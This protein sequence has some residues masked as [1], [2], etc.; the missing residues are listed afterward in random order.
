MT[1]I[2]FYKINLCGYFGSRQRIITNEQPMRGMCDNTNPNKGKSH[3]GKNN[4]VLFR[5]T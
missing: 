3:H 1:T 5:K 2:Q 4:P